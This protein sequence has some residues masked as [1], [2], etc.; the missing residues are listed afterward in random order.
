M[1]HNVR[2][3]KLAEVVLGDQVY[4]KRKDSN[5]WK[6]PGSVVGREGSQVLVR[7][8]G[9]L[10]RVHAVHL[11][12]S[13]TNIPGEN[14]RDESNRNAVV[15]KEVQSIGRNRPIESPIY[16][17]EEVSED[18]HQQGRG[19]EVNQAEVIHVT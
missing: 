8:G 4:Y 2:E 10:V 17:D 13:P 1:K 15:Q 11:K 14:K 19:E 18:V 12:I 3:N 5:E 16:E 6:G 7:H 9:V